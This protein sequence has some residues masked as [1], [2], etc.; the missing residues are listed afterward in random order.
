MASDKDSQ[1]EVLSHHYSETFELL[2]TDVAKRDRLFLYILIVIFLLLL[3]MSAPG[4]MGDLLNNFIRS[5]LRDQSDANLI[6]VSFMG[7]ILLLGLLSLSHTYF[8]T[9]LHVER[10]YKYVYQLEAELSS[11]FESK[12]FSREGEFYKSQR[13]IFSLW[14]KAIFWWL[15]PSL[16][17]L[18]IVAWLIFL[19]GSSEATF[20]YRI[21]GTLISLSILTSL[22]LYMLALLKKK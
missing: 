12:A 10:Q 1:L 2:K 13:R 15:F 22:G 17:L 14:T 18:F 6:D 20:A 11:R 9:V 7:T 19:W 21:V 5:E 4:V 3:Y 16:F 8:Q